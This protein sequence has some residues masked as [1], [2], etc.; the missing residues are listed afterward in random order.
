[1]FYLVYRKDGNYYPKGFLEKFVH[2]FYLEKYKFCFLGLWKF[3]LKCKKFFKIGARKISFL[4]YKELFG[5]L[6][7][8][9]FLSKESY[10]LK[11]E[12]F[13]S[14]SVSWNIR[15]TFFWENIKYFLTLE[16]ESLISQK[17]KKFFSW[18]IFFI[19]SSLSLKSVGSPMIHYYC[20]STKKEYNNATQ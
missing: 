18:W 9:R 6:F 14:V 5:V 15:K 17:Y 8:F 3:L 10:S 2:N 20:L 16:Q 11:Y 7:F 4:N 1:M 13:F 12:K 19:F